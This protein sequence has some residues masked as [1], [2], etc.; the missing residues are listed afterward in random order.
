MHYAARW[1]SEPNATTEFLDWATDSLLREDVADSPPCHFP[2]TAGDLGL[3]CCFSG[4]V[5][6]GRGGFA[7]VSVGD[8]RIATLLVRDWEVLQEG[9]R[10][11]VCGLVTALHDGA[12]G[13]V[14]TVVGLPRILES[15]DPSGSQ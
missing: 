1:S 4:I 6:S 13:G 5:G 14:P 10:V 12:V 8:E 9:R 2:A 15:S 11:E 3:S 7:L